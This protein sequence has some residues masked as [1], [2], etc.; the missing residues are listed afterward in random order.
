MIPL[1]PDFP[2]RKC[3]AEIY[4]IVVLFHWI[5]FVISVEILLPLF[6]FFDEILNCSQTFSIFFPWIYIA[7]INV[8]LEIKAIP[9]ISVATAFAN[10]TPTSVRTFSFQIRQITR[11]RLWIAYKSRID[12]SFAL[13]AIKEQE[14][15]ST[16][17]RF[18]ASSEEL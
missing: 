7:S 8:L 5:I 2:G 11:R 18:L 9:I 14:N 17:T 6:I 13:R 16:A 15:S 10:Q 12:F 1:N 3:F 4:S